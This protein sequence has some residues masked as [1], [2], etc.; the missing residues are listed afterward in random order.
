[1]DNPWPKHNNKMQIHCDIT[2]GPKINAKVS[3]Y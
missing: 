3:K 1:M 2:M